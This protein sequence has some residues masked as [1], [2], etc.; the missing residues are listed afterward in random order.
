M[1]GSS[2]WRR[3]RRWWAAVVGV[4]RLMAPVGVSSGGEVGTMIDKG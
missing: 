4:E 3:R 1:E 2:V